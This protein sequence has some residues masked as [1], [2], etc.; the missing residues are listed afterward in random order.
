[1]EWQTR[2]IFLYLTVCKFWA[3]GVWSS[4]ERMSHNDAPSFTDEEIVTVYL[5]GIMEKHTELSQVHKFTKDHLSEWFPRLP[6]YKGFVY[7]INRIACAFEE[8]LKYLLEQLP[9]E[10]RSNCEKLVDSMPIML[11]KAKRSSQARVASEIANKGYCASKGAY[12]YGVK[13]HMVGERR[14]KHLPV[15]EGVLLSSANTHDLAVFEELSTYLENCVVYAD[16]AYAARELEERLKTQQNVRL[17]TPVKCK[18]GQEKLDLFDQLLST[19]VS[20]IRQPI[21][22]FF[23]WL[24]E[25]T[26]VQVASKVRSYKGLLVHVFGRFTAAALMLLVF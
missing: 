10:F 25:K 21:E 11:A 8:L 3:Q 22:S 7:R 19:A 18:K 13:L 16:K 5:F 1:M 15:P 26:G 9:A 12:Y 2:L 17:L 6:E 14:K 20:S 4:C 23:N 24:Q